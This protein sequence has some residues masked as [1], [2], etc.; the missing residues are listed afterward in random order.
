M[1]SFLIIAVLGLGASL[2]IRR[3]ASGG[4]QTAQSGIGPTDNGSRATEATNQSLSIFAPDEHTWPKL[5]D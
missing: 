4:G 5:G 3:F 1:F 2:V